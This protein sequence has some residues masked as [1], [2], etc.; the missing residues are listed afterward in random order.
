MT[1]EEQL[2]LMKML[3][4][5]GFSREYII[6]TLINCCEDGMSI[7]RAMAIAIHQ[8]TSHAKFPGENENE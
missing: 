3:I 6:W 7:G 2:R 4:G 5:V 1:F 8:T